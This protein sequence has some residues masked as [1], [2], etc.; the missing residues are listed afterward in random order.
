MIK[1]TRKL[2]PK[3]ANRLDIEQQLIE[4]KLLENALSYEFNGKSR[5]RGQPIDHGHLVRAQERLKE[6]DRV[7]GVYESPEY[8]KKQLPYLPGAGTSRVTKVKAHYD[9]QDGELLFFEVK[10]SSSGRIV[11][12]HVSTKSHIKGRIKQK[13]MATKKKAAKKAAK[14]AKKA[15]KKV[16]GDSIRARVEKLVKAKKNNAEIM[17][18]LD[19]DGIAYSISSVRWYASKARA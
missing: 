13:Q 11:V 16:E 18:A 7:R 19:K 2:S 15:A 17:E 4:I 5:L 14:P 12:E 9:E 3:Q 8:Q 1:K 6:L 10:P